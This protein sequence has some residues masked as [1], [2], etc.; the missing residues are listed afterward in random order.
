MSE[1]EKFINERRAR[2]P[3]AW[4]N[5]DAEYQQYAVG[6]LLAEHREKSGIPLTE[7]AR[8]IKRLKGGAS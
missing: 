6:T 4:A 3:K 1:I 8:R 5:V 2:N 7:H